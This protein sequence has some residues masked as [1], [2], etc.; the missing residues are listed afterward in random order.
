MALV[1]HVQSIVTREC[2]QA[3]GYVVEA[4]DGLCLAAFVEPAAAAIWALSCKKVCA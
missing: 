3:G 2:C 1:P 4:T